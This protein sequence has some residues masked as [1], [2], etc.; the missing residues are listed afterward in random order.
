M[1]GN[2]RLIACSFNETESLCKLALRG[3]GYP[4]SVATQGAWAVRWLVEHGLPGVQILANLLHRFEEIDILT[5]KPSESSVAQMWCWHAESSLLCPVLTGL[6]LV[7]FSDVWFKRA[8][9]QLANV[10]CPGLV[11]PFTVRAS[12]A[13]EGHLRV[14]WSAR[15]FVCDQGQLL[16]REEN[17]GNPTSLRHQS[18]EVPAV[19]DTEAVGMTIHCRRDDVRSCSNYEPGSLSILA[20]RTERSLIAEKLMLELNAYAARTFAPSSEMSRQSGA[21]AG[22]SD[23]D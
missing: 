20:A 19:A 2:D 18:D 10:C 3:I 7:D 4:W 5:A 21:G 1:T 6:T 9:V 17:S 13:M 8:G 22:L 11:L 23:N 15:D 12:I 14:T 16:Y